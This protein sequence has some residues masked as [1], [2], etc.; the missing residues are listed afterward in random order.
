MLRTILIKIIP[1][2]TLKVFFLKLLGAKIG[3]GVKIGYF[4]TIHTQNYSNIIIGN[5]VEIGHNVNIKVSKLEIDN[6][7]FIGNNVLIDG[8]GTL[9]IGKAVSVPTFLIDTTG[10]VEVGDYVGLAPNGTIY[11]HNYSHVWHNPGIKHETCK[12]KIGMRAWM[13]AGTSVLNASIGDESLIAAGSVVLQDIPNNVFAIGNPAR[14]IKENKFKKA[15]EGLFNNTVFQKDILKSYKNDNILFI[16]ELNE[17]NEEYDIIICN[18]CNID[19]DKKKVSIL[20]VNKNYIY[21][22]KKS[23]LPTIRELRGWG[24]FLSY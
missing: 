16:N 6:L 7:S 2:S 20:E 24:I 23:I 14:V 1:S 8:N 17:L 18:K 10:G 3:T 13:G 19:T 21:N 15:E 5:Y 9:S 11:S 12:V 22:M 4:S